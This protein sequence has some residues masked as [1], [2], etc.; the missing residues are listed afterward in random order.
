MINMMKNTKKY[1]C[2]C[3]GYFT[4]ENEPGHFDICPVCFWEDDNIQAADPDYAGGA[5]KISLNNAR[6]NFK[7]FGAAE[8][9]C[10][11]L[12]RPP[13]TEEMS[14]AEN[15]QKSHKI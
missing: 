12:V 1:K 5:N 3:C 2:P 14:E 9:Q 4:L 10:L 6:E 13:T 11:D 8:K 15:T 7:K